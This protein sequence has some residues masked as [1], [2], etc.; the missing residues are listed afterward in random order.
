LELRV[1]V[2]RD[3]GDAVA[4]ADAE[5]PLQDVGPAVAAVEELAV[6]EPQIPI[7]HGLARAIQPPRAAGELHRRQR[8]FHEISPGGICAVSIANSATC[9]ECCSPRPLAGSGPSRW[10][11]ADC[12]GT[13][14]RCPRRPPRCCG[15]AG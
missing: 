7:Y 6:R 11:P 9:R 12:T 2:G 10:R 14:R 8:K 3:V 13:W 5:L 4:V 15:A 1:R